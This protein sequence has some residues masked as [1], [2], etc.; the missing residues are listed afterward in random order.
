MYEIPDS[1]VALVVTSPPYPMISKWDSLFGCVDFEK[2]HSLLDKVWK[3]CFRTLIPGGILCINVGDATRRIDNN[4]YCF[5]NYAR[6][7][8]SCY[9]IGFT[10]LIPIFWKKISNK[11]NSFLGS[12]FLPTNGYITQDCE[13]IAIL[14]KGGIRKFPPK[15]KRRYASKFTKDER[16]RW[17]TQIWEIPGKR[18]ASKTSSF[19]EEIPYRLIRM[20]S[21]VGDIVVDPFSGTHIVGKVAEKLGRVFIG[22]EIRDESSQM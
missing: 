5:P 21:I 19:P 17:F 6:V 22:Y 10:P 15:D 16:D 14:R 1:S 4:F 13:Y 7:V 20:F 18:G 2:Q 9:K 8:M 3:E 12:G 11:P